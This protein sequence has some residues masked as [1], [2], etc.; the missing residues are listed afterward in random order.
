MLVDYL[1][2]KNIKPLIDVVK[3]GLYIARNFLK[4]SGNSFIGDISSNIHPY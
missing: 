2:I 4:I 3:C 1:E